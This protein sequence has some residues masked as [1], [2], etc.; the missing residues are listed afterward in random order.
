MG[1]LPVLGGSKY[2]Y[3]SDYPKKQ[4]GKQ[5][6][7]KYSRAATRFSGYLL[8]TLHRSCLCSPLSDHLFA[9]SNAKVQR[10]IHARFLLAHDFQGFGLPKTV[11]R[12]PQPLMPP[13]RSAQ[14]LSEYP[15]MNNRKVRDW[16]TLAVPFASGQ[17][18][19]RKWLFLIVNSAVLASRLP[20][21]DW[22]AWGRLTLSLRC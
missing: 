21:L 13:C 12:S 6:R 10:G 16:M 14:Y 2:A 7:H 18:Q 22:G 5:T 15:A 17:H 4:G 3:C 19:H 8:P 1:K 11:K 20:L 9:Q